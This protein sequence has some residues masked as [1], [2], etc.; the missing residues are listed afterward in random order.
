MRRPKPAQRGRRRTPAP[1]SP[2]H[3]LGRRI[4]HAG[5]CRGQTRQLWSG[6]RRW[7][8]VHRR[9]R[10]PAG[11]ARCTD[12]HA[13]P[14]QNGHCCCRSLLSPRF[15]VATRRCTL[16]YETEFPRVFQADYRVTFPISFNEKGAFLAWCG[17][18]II[19]LPFD[20]IS[21]ESF[22]SSSELFLNIKTLDTKI[23]HCSN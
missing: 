9:R 12:F 21:I 6:D 3:F 10:R 2:G 23:I 13:L 16:G 15:P 8:L 20:P 11:P 4:S 1:A 5:T 7:P 22:P 19:L 18:R 17:K 14:L